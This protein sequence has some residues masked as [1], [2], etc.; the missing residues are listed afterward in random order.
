MPR[1]DVGSTSRS[2]LEAI[3]DWGNQPAWREFHKRYDPLVRRC[4]AHLRLDHVAADEVCQET[5]VQIANRLRSFVYDPA[6]SFRGWVWK[7]S[8]HEAM[9]FLARRAK[10][11]MLSLDE[12]D[13]GALGSQELLGPAASVPGEADA[14]LGGDNEG[15]LAL[16]GLFRQ[17]EEIQAAVRR[18][19][20]PHTWEAFWLVGV[21]FWTVDATASH[22]QISPASVI[23]AKGRVTKMLQREAR[24]RGLD[25]R[26]S[27][28]AEQ[29]TERR[30]KKSASRGGHRGPPH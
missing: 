20:K 3:R 22:L 23:K 10:D 14:D 6:G 24:R 4:L 17:A 7:V 8:H 13:D 12:R 26:N 28:G 1:V 11:R 29:P 15:C 5:W 2:Q 27:M 19:V 21:A 16:A 18:A 30:A 25:S 9:K